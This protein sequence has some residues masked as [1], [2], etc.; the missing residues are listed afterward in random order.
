MMRKFNVDFINAFVSFYESN[1]F[2]N[3]QGSEFWLIMLRIY[4]KFKTIESEESEVEIECDLMPKSIVPN[5]M[6]RPQTELIL[7]LLK[8]V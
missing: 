5:N 8:G 6:N 2:D 3:L 4:S 7:P 1:R